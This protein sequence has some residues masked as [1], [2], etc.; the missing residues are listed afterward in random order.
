MRVWCGMGYGLWKGQSKLPI[1][2]Y[3]RLSSLCLCQ[4]TNQNIPPE[5]KYTSIEEEKKS[6]M[7]SLFDVRDMRV[8]LRVC[9]CVCERTPTVTS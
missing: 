5:T 2:F 9:F 4:M 6:Q 8:H 3:D 1:T 7:P